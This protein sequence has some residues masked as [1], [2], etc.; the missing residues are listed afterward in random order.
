[1]EK[2][3]SQWGAIVRKEGVTPFFVVCGMEN[4]NQRMGET[5]SIGSS[6]FARLKDPIIEGGVP[7][8]ASYVCKQSQQQW[9]IPML[10]A[11]DSQEDSTTF[12]FSKN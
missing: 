8:V 2:T 6:N 10:Q 11:M 12:T 3:K 9:S 7:N 5:T 1:V 4:K